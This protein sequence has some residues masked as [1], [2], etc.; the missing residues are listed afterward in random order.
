MKKT[1]MSYLRDYMVLFLVHIVKTDKAA[2]VWLP[3]KTYFNRMLSLIDDIT[4][5]EVIV[6]RRRWPCKINK[7]VIIE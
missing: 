4:I 7:Y 5:E 1:T 6:G 3:K 2:W